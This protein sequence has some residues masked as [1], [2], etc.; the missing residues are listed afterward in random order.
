MNQI[1]GSGPCASSYAATQP[2][3]PEPL[4]S[5]CPRTLPACSVLNAAYSGV[6]SIWCHAEST[7]RENISA[8][9]LP[10]ARELLPGDGQ[11]AAEL[12]ALDGAGHGGAPL[13][14]VSSGA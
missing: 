13:D 8:G 1:S 11:E 10:S 12:A 2:I 5:R 14:G 4:I 3:G 9:P 6:P 7:A